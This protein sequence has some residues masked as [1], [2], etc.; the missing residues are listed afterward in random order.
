MSLNDRRTTFKVL[1]NSY[2]TISKILLT[3][4]YKRYQRATT[5]LLIGYDKFTKG[6]LKSYQR[7]ITRLL[8][9]YYSY[10]TTGPRDHGLHGS[11]RPCVHERKEQVEQWIRGQRYRCSVEAIQR[12]LASRPSR[13][14]KVYIQACTITVYLHTCR[15]IDSPRNQR[16]ASRSRA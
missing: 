1:L 7:V 13:K 15:T 3:S 9:Y 14:K 10:G 16:R 8:T 12:T 5:K 11:T 6:P 4:Y 2:Q